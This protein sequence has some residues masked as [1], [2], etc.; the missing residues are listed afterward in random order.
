MNN[1]F[2]GTVHLASGF[3]FGIII[4]FVV[5]V[6]SFGQPQLHFDPAF[7]EIQGQGNQSHSLLLDASAHTIN[8]TD[9]QEELSLPLGVVVIDISLFIVPSLHSTD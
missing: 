9:M 5:L 6:L 7:L 1:L 8:F 4:T 2:A 3:S